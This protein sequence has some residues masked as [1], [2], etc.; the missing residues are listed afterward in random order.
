MNVHLP[1]S[2][3][4]ATPTRFDAT[5]IEADTV[6]L[7]D[8]FRRLW[9]R[10]WIVIACSVGVALLFAL[11]TSLLTPMYSAQSLVLLDPRERQVVTTQQVVSDLKLSNPVIESE[12][13]VIR[14]NV[15]LQSLVGSLDPAMVETLDPRNQPVP[16]WHRAIERATGWMTGLLGGGEVS[17][18][19]PGGTASDA[20]AVA[21][22]AI[23]AAIDTRRRV[24]AAIQRS[25][26]VRQLGSSYVISVRMEHENPVVAAE[27]TNA[28]ASTYIGSQLDERVES[29]RRATRWLEDRV[30]ELGQQVVDA[31]R[32]VETYKA[33]RLLVDGV[34]GEIAARQAGEVSSQLAVARADLASAEARLRQ[35]TEAIASAGVTAAADT[36]TSPLIA[37]L[38]Q[39]LSTLRTE[40]AELSARFGASNPEIAR[41]EAQIGQVREDLER[42]VSNVVEV[43]RTEAEVAGIRVASLEESLSGLE[44]QV[45]GVSSAAVDLRQLEREA[46]ALRDVYE[47]L[48]SRLKETR[49][50]STLPEAQARIVQTAEVPRAPF[51]PRTKLLIAFGAAL[52]GV[53]GLVG[54]FL[55]EMG[56]RGYKTILDL[57]RDT[58][59]PV[60]ASIPR[61]KRLGARD[62]TKRLAGSSVPDFEAAM[63]QL[64]TRILFGTEEDGAR[65]ILVTSSVP[66]EGKTTT[67][68]FLA[69]AIG[70]MGRSVV[71]LDLDAQR[72]RLREAFGSTDRATPHDLLTGDA[73]L[74]DA[75]ETAEKLGV[76]LVS[77][78]PE[79][80]SLSDVITPDAIEGLI[81]ALKERY[82]VVVVDSP[83]VLAVSDALIVGAATDEILYL[84][85]S[86]T[87]P[88]RAVR[89]GLASLS[90]VGAGS[91]D[92]V[93]TMVDRS[94]A[95]GWSNQS[96]SGY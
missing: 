73:A 83:P 2:A 75:V 94:D 31:E 49:S 56:A 37:T 4:S 67:A 1:V 66:G 62:L 36:L 3:T 11:L 33:E 43:Y 65:S 35:V 82:D 32:A 57:E 80:D 7:N 39:Q 24:V 93:M 19:D 61:I 55:A 60:L 50:Q 30:A 64:R 54:V 6:D 17:P 44:T 40:R 87:T 26:E 71:I 21:N 76:D 20:D 46:S 95:D 22:D 59:L 78:A 52:G 81:A 84:V 13:S 25:L 51:S 92:L 8:L 23:N 48:L 91:I 45:L 15:L 12:M 28:I 69:R 53:L 27:V 5:E 16:E 42:E 88:R 63:R 34:G 14:S 29:A 86:K 9:R 38:R 10:K 74:D 79:H 70:R 85:A 58:K 90:D 47:A 77:S 72:S 68:I 41:V 96:Y 18:A 89:Q